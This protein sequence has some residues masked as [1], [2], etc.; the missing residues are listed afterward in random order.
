[1]HISKVH[2]PDSLKSQLLTETCTTRKTLRRLILEAGAEL[3]EQL[4]LH[5][6]ADVKGGSNDLTNCIR[7]RELFDSM[8]KT[9]S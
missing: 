3:V 5:G 1:M 2:L 4:L 9:V 6:V 8:N 7:I